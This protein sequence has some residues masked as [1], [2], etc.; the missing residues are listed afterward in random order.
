MNGKFRN[1]LAYMHQD[2]LSNKWPKF[3]QETKKLDHLRGEDSF[4]LLQF[5]VELDDKK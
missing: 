3:I 5:K 1:F 2:D 4:E